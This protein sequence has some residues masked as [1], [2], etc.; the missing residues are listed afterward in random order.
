MK[1]VRALGAS[2]ERRLALA[3]EGDQ[4]G[5]G[6]L[7]GF[8]PCRAHGTAQ[9]VEQSALGLVAHGIGNGFRPALRD[10][11]SKHAS[12]LHDA[13]SSFGG[14]Q[15]RISSTLPLGAQVPMK[16]VVSISPLG[17]IR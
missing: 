4:R 11:A 13:Q 5:D 12:D 1:S 14:A 9:H 15:A 7:H 3:E 8:V 2:P 16:T 10:E 6:T 17:V